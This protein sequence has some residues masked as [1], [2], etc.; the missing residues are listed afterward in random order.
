MFHV[1]ERLRVR[2]G[3]QASSSLDGNC[4]AFV[5]QHAGVSLFVIASDG[6]DLP[7][8]HQWEHVSVSTRE[9]TPTWQEMCAV[10]QIFWDA[11]DV[12]LQLHPARSQYVND[13]PYVLHLWRSVN[14]R[15]PLP[16]MLLV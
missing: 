5:V 13:H 14:C 9:R 3:P 2:T 6:L 16:P 4:G 7:V 11:E 10:K 1:P 8:P 15:Q 12:V